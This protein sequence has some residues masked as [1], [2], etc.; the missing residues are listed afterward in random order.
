MSSDK[1]STVPVAPKGVPAEKPPA[2]AD[3]GSDDGLLDSLGK[4]V[5]APIEGAA[6]PEEPTTDPRRPPVAPG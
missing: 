2:S 1:L 3:Q 6:E 4:A 5:A